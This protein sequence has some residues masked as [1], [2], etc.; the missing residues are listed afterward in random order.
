LEKSINFIGGFG[1]YWAL[2]MIEKL[3][4][5]VPLVA[6]ERAL[7]ASSLRARLI[8]NNIANADTPGFKALRLNFEEKLA[9]ELGVGREGGKLPLKMTHPRHLPGKGMLNPLA[10]ETSSGTIYVDPYS[11]YRLDGNNVDIDLEMAEEAKNAMHYAALIELATRRFASLRSA[12]T[13]R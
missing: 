9:E 3:F 6:L 1:F 12:I 11:T 13:G 7:D 2:Q 10:I 4:S 8:A 5:E